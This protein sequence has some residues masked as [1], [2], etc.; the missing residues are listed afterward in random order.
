MEA[1]V[2]VCRVTKRLWH[3]GEN[4]EAEGAPQPDRRRI[5]FD[6]HIELHR[7]VTVCACLFKDMAAQSPAYAPAT[8]RRV[9]NKVGI[10]NVWPPATQGERD[11]CSRSR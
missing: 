8:L 5:R 6:N 11:E 4:P 1:D 3:R 2:S 7:P 10:G 9:D